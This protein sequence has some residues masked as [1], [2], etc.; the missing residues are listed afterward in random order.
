MIGTCDFQDGVQVFLLEGVVE[1]YGL[2]EQLGT[3]LLVAEARARAP[4]KVVGGG[5]KEACDV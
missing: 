1:G 4:G 2:A 5:R 3:E